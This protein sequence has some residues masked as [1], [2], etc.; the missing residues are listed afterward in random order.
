VEG[1][2]SA[3]QRDLA[4]FRADRFLCRVSFATSAWIDRYPRDA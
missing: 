3:T 2:S 4:K 1:E